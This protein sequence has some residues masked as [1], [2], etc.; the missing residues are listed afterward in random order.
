MTG[1]HHHPH[2]GTRGVGRQ[3]ATCHTPAGYP[4][5]HR[6]PDLEFAYCLIKA[7]SKIFLKEHKSKRQRDDDEG[8]NQEVSFRTR[9]KK[10]L[11]V[12]E[13]RLFFPL[14]ISPISV[15]RS[16]LPG[17]WKIS[18]WVAGLG[19]DPG[20]RPRPRPHPT[21]HLRITPPALPAGL[22]QGASA[23][24]SHPLY[25]TPICSVPSLRKCLLTWG[26]LIPKPALNES[27]PVGVTFETKKP[28]I[29]A[30]VSLGLEKRRLEPGSPWR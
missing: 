29:L 14:K 4:H 15:L 10:C 24:A 11:R 3:R 27:P 16:I 18:P 5:Q 13:R 23:E 2:L 30:I 9:G 25:V 26:N 17:M 20:H 22:P 1:S 7:F 6:P 19:W 21:P 8:S 12:Q 28:G